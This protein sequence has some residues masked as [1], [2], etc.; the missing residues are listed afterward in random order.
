[1][2]DEF[3]GATIFSLLLLGFLILINQL[4]PFRNNWD[5]AGGNKKII[6]V[7]FLLLIKKYA[8]KH[9]LELSINELPTCK[10]LCHNIPRSHRK[11]NCTTADL[12]LWG[13]FALPDCKAGKKKLCLWQQGN[14]RGN[15]ESEVHMLSDIFFQLCERG[16]LEAFRQILP[17]GQKFLFNGP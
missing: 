8:G 12:V 4:P 5:S 13:G 2:K 14:L 15:Q 11:S 16:W 9:S 3:L 7:L 1:M 17:R 6:F 10:P